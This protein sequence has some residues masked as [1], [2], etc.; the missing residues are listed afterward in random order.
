M[1]MNG[2]MIES[3]YCQQKGIQMLHLINRNGRYYYNRRTP[4]KYSDYDSR[5]FIRVAL[6]T[7]CKREAMRLAIF[8]NDKIEAYWKELSKSSTPLSEDHYKSV[9][10]LVRLMGF[11]YINAGQVAAL[12][13]PQLLERFCHLQKSGMN[14]K[15]VE[16][17][18]G[19]L[20]KP[21]L[22]LDGLLNKYWEYARPK[23]LNKSPKQIKK[24]KNPRIK[25]MNN[26][27]KIVGNKNVTDLSRDDLLLF[28]NWW[29][30]RIENKNMTT[31]S[32]NKDITFCKVII[33]TV[34]D[35]LKLN[36]D[37]LHL[38]KKLS[39]EKDDHEAK[40]LPFETGYI[41]NVLLNPI[42]LEGLE[43]QA[44]SI[45]F[46]FAETGAG[47]AELSGLMP[48]DIRLDD[49][50]PHI[51][52]TPRKHTGLKTKYRKR[53]IPLVGYALE[54]FRIC[55]QGFP[56]YRE[57]PDVLS[58]LLN[59]FLNERKLMPSPMHSVYSLRHSFQDRLVAA[60]V[61][62]R[63]QAQLMG[64]KFNRPVY[65]EGGTLAQKLE[66]MTKIKLRKQQ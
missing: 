1:G 46:A 28:R 15:H 11:T 35:N 30:E 43:E 3:G 60:N 59:K 7:D 14:E 54:A 37:I 34:N 16:G 13:L 21:L 41:T 12:P 66:W 27:I 31:N 22:K 6:N 33:E 32:A 47:I 17:L 25:A 36:L 29:F 57:N 39:F 9:L 19:G 55:P 62:D 44:K 56:K 26:L 23:T 2:D 50:V 20:T 40:R 48:E 45:L 49:A 52:I 8:Q 63:I 5:K 38:F 24:W 64:H 51:A 53:T 4:K 58:N 65:G 42:H 61:P 18:L 10:D